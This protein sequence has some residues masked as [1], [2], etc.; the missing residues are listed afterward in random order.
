MPY[1]IITNN[2]PKKSKAVPLSEKYTLSIEEASQ[3]F[4]I[5]HVR[6]RSIIH[7][8]PNAD[9]LLMKGNR[10]QI[11]RKKFEKFID[12]VSVI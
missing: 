9:F 12:D 6:L 5:G 10:L 1:F 2:S 3:Y 4:G 11:K 7:A 8:N